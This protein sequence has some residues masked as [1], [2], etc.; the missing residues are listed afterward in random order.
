M[1]IILPNATKYT[2]QFDKKIS[3]NMTEQVYGRRGGG[4]WEYRTARMAVDC[5]SS[6]LIFEQ[7]VQKSKLPVDI[8][9]LSPLLAFLSSSYKTIKHNTRN[10]WYAMHTEAMIFNKD[11]FK[12]P[13]KHA[14]CEWEN[15]TSDI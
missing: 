15:G 9:S 12:F 7:D 8:F 4:G 2:N 13:R 10:K 14:M 5:N 1:H 6:K 11:S 3:Q